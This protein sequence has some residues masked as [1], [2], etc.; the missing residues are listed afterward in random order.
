MMI[1]LSLCIAG[2]AGCDNGKDNITIIGGADKATVITVSEN[3]DNE[4]INAEINED[5]NEDVS[6]NPAEDPIDQDTDK[7]NKKIDDDRALEAIRK[8]CFSMNPDLESMAEDEYPVYWE[9]ESSDDKEIVVLYRSYT[10][11]LIRYHIDATSGDVYVTEFVPGITEEEEK[12][13]ES[14]NVNDYIE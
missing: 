4:T 1:V 8:Y 5:V 7:D 13:S 9:I 12:T 14:F 11:A 2:L 3:T 10:G 6:E